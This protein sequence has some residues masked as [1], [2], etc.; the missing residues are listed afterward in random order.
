MKLAICQKK[1]PR[2]A[3]EARGR[4][5][6]R[7]SRPLQLFYGDRDL[8]HRV[9]GRD[10]ADGRVVI[11]SVV[12]RRMRI[13]DVFLSSNSSMPPEPGAANQSFEGAT[14]AAK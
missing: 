7:T 11:G 10:Y 5:E 9:R 3:G 2:F 14:M 8:E 13:L 4:R 6:L 12:I 1:P